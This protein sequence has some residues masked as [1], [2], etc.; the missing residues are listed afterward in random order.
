MVAESLEKWH[1]KM[2]DT[3]LAYRI[4]KKAATRTTPY[5]LTFGQ[6]AVFPMEINAI[7]SLSYLGLKKIRAIIHKPDKVTLT[8][9]VMA[10][11]LKAYTYD[12]EVIKNAE[13]MGKSELV[14]ISMS[15]IYRCD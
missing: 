14:N 8:D 12:D 5:A 9:K 1:E 2:R 7:S 6:D 15:G 3:L 4:S 13:A 11:D 10:V